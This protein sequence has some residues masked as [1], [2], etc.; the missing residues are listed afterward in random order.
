MAGHGAVIRVKQL[1]MAR[2]WM[3]AAQ[4]KPSFFHVDH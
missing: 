1:H 3:V 4:I 2:C